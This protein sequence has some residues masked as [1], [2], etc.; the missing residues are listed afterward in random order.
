MLNDRVYFVDGSL[1]TGPGTRLAQALAEVPALL[2]P[3]E[4]FGK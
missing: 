4:T 1:L 2:N 3:V